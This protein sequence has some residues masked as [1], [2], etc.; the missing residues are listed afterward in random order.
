MIFH[1]KNGFKL[2]VKKLRK[3]QNAYYSA[4]YRT[5]VKK[6][7]PNSN[8][9]TQNTWR[10]SKTVS[11]FWPTTKSTWPTTPI[12]QD[13]IFHLS[14]DDDS[15]KWQIWVHLEQSRDNCAISWSTV[16]TCIPWGVLPAP[17]NTPQLRPCWLSG[18]TQVNKWCTRLEPPSCMTDDCWCM[19]SALTMF[20]AC[21]RN[22]DIHSNKSQLLG[23]NAVSVDVDE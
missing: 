9:I 14:Y 12:Y 17:T 21:L 16:I 11:K 20:S 23:S 8:C 22:T 13:V 7:T 5:Q 10:H 2:H 1:R 4:F 3:W 15:W 18:Q 19:I 6:L